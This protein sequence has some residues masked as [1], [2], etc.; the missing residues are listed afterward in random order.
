MSQ[1]FDQVTVPQSVPKQNPWPIK[2]CEH[3]ACVHRN[4]T[5]LL[6]KYVL[7]YY[8]HYYNKTDFVDLRKY[9]ERKLVSPLCYGS[10]RPV[11]L[12]P[13]MMISPLYENVLGYISQWK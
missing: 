12:S 8:Y 10:N 4:D 9:C 11:C 3:G 6:S 1:R 2:A 13:Q 5:L 7:Y